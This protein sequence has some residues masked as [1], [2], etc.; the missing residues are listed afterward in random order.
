MM[1]KVC[2]PNEIGITYLRPWAATKLHNRC[3]G[4]C[5]FL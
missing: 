1:L 3:P 5:G 4:S 2:A